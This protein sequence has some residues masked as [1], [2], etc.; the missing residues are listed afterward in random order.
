SEIIAVDRNL[1]GLRKY[2]TDKPYKNR[3]RCVR[4][5]VRDEKDLVRLMAYRP[6]VVVDLLPVPLHK[7]VTEAVVSHGIHL[8]T[9]SYTGAEMKRLARDAEKKEI[10]LLPE[11]GMDPGL[12]LILL[13]EA[14]RSLDRVDEVITYGAGFPEKSAA[15]NPLNYKVTWNF[16]GV[17]K[18]YYRT[19][20]LI[21]DGQTFQ[22]AEHELFHPD[23]IHE[24]EI[25]GLGTLEA[26]PNGDALE[27]VELLGLD[28]KALKKLARYVLRWPG[29]AAFWKIMVDLKLLDHEPVLIDG[30]SVD[31]K[32]FLAAVMEPLL[33]YRENERDVVV[34]RVEASG[35]KQGKPC[36]IV[37]RIIDRRD[38]E[39]GLTAM[40]RTVGF[41]ASIG[42]LMITE[43]VIT[44]RGLLSPVK[45]VPFES[46]RKALSQRGIQIHSEIV[47]R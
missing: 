24:I 20:R 27:Y 47:S 9:A 29:H 4:A 3:V 17:L 15:D 31:K 16:E 43:G 21:R 13:G 40:S 41:T 39:T 42:A 30:V 44:S 33:Q 22:I 26:F 25:R 10:T 18:S 6:E 32:R 23:R 37:H 34:V 8:V 36:S 19:A 11:M 46:F 35:V 2:I 7:K 38:L 14:V 12:D 5:D 1:G 45:D 28:A